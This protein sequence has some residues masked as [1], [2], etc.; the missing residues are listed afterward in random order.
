MV[1]DDTHCLSTGTNSPRA[2]STVPL[3][4]ITSSDS[5]EHPSA[6]C[7]DDEGHIS[8]PVHVI[9]SPSCHEFTGSSA[10][11]QL[12]KSNTIG[13]VQFSDSHTRSRISQTSLKNWQFT[14]GPI[15]RDFSSLIPSFENIKRSPNSK[16]GDTHVPIEEL[17]LLDGAS[18]QDRSKAVESPGSECL[19]TRIDKAREGSFQKH[20]RRTPA[21]SAISVENIKTDNP[22]PESEASHTGTEIVSPEPV[23]PIRMLRVKNSIPQ[24]MK[25]LPHLP[26]ETTK[27]SPESFTSGEDKAGGQFESNEMKSNNARVQPPKFRLRTTRSSTC[28]LDHVGER[29]P[30]GSTMS[31]LDLTVT[32]KPKLKVRVP[33][34]PTKQWQSGAENTMLRSSAI[35]QCNSLVDLE[36]CSR[37][38][39]FTNPCRLEEKFMPTRVPNYTDHGRESPVIDNPRISGSSTPSSDQFDLECN[40]PRRSEAPDHQRQQECQSEGMTLPMEEYNTLSVVSEAMANNHHGLRQKLSMFRLK[41]V[42]GRGPRVDRLTSPP[43]DFQ[44]LIKSGRQVATDYESISVNQAISARSE[45]KSGRVKR[46]ANGAKKVVRSYVRRAWDRS[47]HA[48]T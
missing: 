17:K 43:T 21:T 10:G 23:S 36:H 19:A 33:R 20:H 6:D 34:S 38:D 35:T 14:F 5:L 41:I 1:V 42:G 39:M 26:V 28:S 13:P 31:Q 40:L 46:W 37:L 9:R 27:R 30:L 24:F 4:K 16:T 47:S 44:T 2:P 7:P 8:Q 18:E 12:P 29:E 25:A 48:S 45:K 22:S 11:N 3:P 32:T 15:V